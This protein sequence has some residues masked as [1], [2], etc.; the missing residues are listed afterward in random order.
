MCSSVAELDG[1]WAE[2]GEALLLFPLT[3]PV[4]RALLQLMHAALPAPHDAVRFL[5]V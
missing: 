2:A 1:F 5:S 4:R 3:E